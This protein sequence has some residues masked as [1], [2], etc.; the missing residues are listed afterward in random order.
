MVPFEPERL[1]P[2]HLRALSPYQPG[3]A[4]AEIQREFG[5]R[6]VVKLASNENPLGPSPRAMAAILKSV[7]SVNRYP[8]GSCFALRE[9]LAPHLGVTPDQLVFGSGADE[10][11]ELLV[12]TF[13]APGDEAVRKP[14][15]G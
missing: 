7:G 8:D 11:L 1:V 4:I 6:D 3:R 5:L 15:N 9:R 2:E 14:S 10:I 13:L 12:K